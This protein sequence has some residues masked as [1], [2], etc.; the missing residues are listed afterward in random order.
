M[1]N[2]IFLSCDAWKGKTKNPIIQETTSLVSTFFSKIK[3]ALSNSNEQDISS[4]EEIQESTPVI[5]PALNTDWI[6]NFFAGDNFL[7]SGAMEM[8]LEETAPEFEKLPQTLDKEGVQA[9][10]KHLHRIKPSFKIIG[11]DDMA[12]AMS[13]LEK[14]CTII[15][16]NN[17]INKRLKILTAA[18][19][20]FLPLVKEQYSNIS[21]LAGI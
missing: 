1:Y 5:Q 13:E 4:P 2:L 19:H 16:D 3:S 15:N 6:E 14:D 8:F 12:D 11:L 20:R 18:F 9:F 21:K 10:Q 17:A 7:A